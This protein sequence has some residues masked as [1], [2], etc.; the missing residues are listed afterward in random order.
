MLDRAAAADTDQKGWLIEMNDAGTKSV[1]SL[2]EGRALGRPLG[3]WTPDQALGLR[4]ARRCDAE[5]FVKAFLR[6]E[7]PFITIVP[8]TGV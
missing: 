4:L 6:N 5:D 7:A 3:A 2:S 1:L 8:F